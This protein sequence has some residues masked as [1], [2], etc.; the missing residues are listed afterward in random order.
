MW[1]DIVEKPIALV[2]AHPDDETLAAGAHLKYWPDLKVIQVTDG[3]PRDGADARREGFASWSE[4]ALARS[5]ELERALREGQAEHASRTELGIADQQAI[6]RIGEV[7]ERLRDAL[8]EAAV[9]I[10]HSYEGGHPDHDACSLACRAALPRRAELWEFAGYHLKNHEIESGEFLNG[11]AAIRVSLA[12]DDL[13]RK[14]KMLACFE[15]QRGVLAGL[16]HEVESFRPAPK[17]DFTLP[18]HT[19]ALLYETWGFAMDGDRWRK[20]AGEALHCR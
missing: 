17:V 2:V 10:T 6:V 14:E 11:N 13:M 18:P 4:Y 19:G 9:V 1:L 12:G 16:R 15:T 8:A 3:A 20:W 5:R 7:I